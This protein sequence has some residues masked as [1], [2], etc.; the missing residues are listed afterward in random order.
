MAK[1]SL[2]VTVSLLLKMRAASLRVTMTPNASH[3]VVLVEEQAW[4]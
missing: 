4:L 1:T 2:C 3:V